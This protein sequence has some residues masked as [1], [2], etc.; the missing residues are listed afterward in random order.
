MIKEVDP[1]LWTTKRSKEMK[2]SHRGEALCHLKKGRKDRKT[3]LL[4]SLYWANE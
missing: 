2:L 3:A 1:I 4:P